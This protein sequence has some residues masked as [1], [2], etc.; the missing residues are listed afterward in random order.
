MGSVWLARVRKHADF[1]RFFAV[2]TVLAQHAA[3]PGFRKMFLDETRIASAISHANVASILDAGE[4][5]DSLYMVMEWVEGDSLQA[6]MTTV[7]A[8]D[9]KIAPNIVL[10]IMADACAGL[11]AVH[12]ARDRAGKPLDIVHRDLS[13]HNIL[14][15]AQGLPKLVDFGVARARDRLSDTTSSGTLKGKVRY[16]SPEYASG[17]PVDRRSDLWGIGAVL[18]RLLEGRSPLEAENN[19][20]VLRMLLDKTAPDPMS[21]GVPPTLAA[22][23]LRC[24]EVDP[25]KRFATAEDVRRALEGVMLDLALHA[26]TADVATYLDEQLGGQVKRRRATIDA[27]L[28]ALDQAPAGTLPP[29]PAPL[30]LAARGP[31]HSSSWLSVPDVAVA[32]REVTVLIHAG[33]RAAALRRA[34]ALRWALGLSAVMT[35]GMIASAL[36]TR[37]RPLGAT[38]IVAA[39]APHAPGSANV[40]PEATK[41]VPLA[42]PTGSV[43]ADVAPVPSADSATSPAA[44]AASPSSAP[45]KSRSKKSGSRGTAKTG[46]SSVPSDVFDDRK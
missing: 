16:M 28:A 20:A 8:A 46:V 41:D 24:L 25:A 17:H 11:H 29:T 5:Q 26:T 4:E 3:D 35:A 12:E 34:R 42:P 44:A 27:T 37:A 38:L 10:R 1:E 2:K 43:P 31:A 30:S 32:T 18:Y 6:L 45:T 39:S 21:A 40:P 13:P 22:V 19:Y 15:S 33:P 9:G 23:I 36:V 7:E 14:I